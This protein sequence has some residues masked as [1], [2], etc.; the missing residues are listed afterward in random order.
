M[1]T[2]WRYPRQRCSGSWFNGWDSSSFL[3]WF[4]SWDWSISNS[5]GGFIPGISIWDFAWGSCS[6]YLEEEYI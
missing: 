6:Q 3:N 4:Y 5:E 1:K 2:V